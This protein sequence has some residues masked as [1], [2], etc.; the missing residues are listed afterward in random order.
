MLINT[1]AAAVKDG[2]VEIWHGETLITARV[3]WRRGTRAGL[4]TEE[5]VPVEEIL[6]LSRSSAL[7]LT[8]AIPT[9]PQ[10]ERRR[11]PRCNVR[12][13]ETGRAMEFVA[14]TLVAGL[15]AASASMAVYEALSRP[16][17]LI[18]ASM[19]G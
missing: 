7:Q 12:S 17:A 1:T 19:F 6:T 11:V 4:R 9:W 13:R 18:E 14:I 16:L 15:M 8:A 2:Q 10:V 5:R 3:V